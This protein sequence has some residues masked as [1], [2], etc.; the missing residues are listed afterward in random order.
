M[1]NQRKVF[2]SFILF[3]VIPPRDF[4]GSGRRAIY[5]QGFGEKGHLFSGFWEKA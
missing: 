5:F 3:E 2:F 1:A 4:G